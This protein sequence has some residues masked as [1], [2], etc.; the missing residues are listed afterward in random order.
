MPYSNL[1]STNFVNS[2]IL[3]WFSFSCLYDYFFWFIQVP[4][5]G[6]MVAMLKKKHN[7]FEVLYGWFLAKAGF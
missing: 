1:V 3:I 4:T 5:V 2:I 6:E 7:M